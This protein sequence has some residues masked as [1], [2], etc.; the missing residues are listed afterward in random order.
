MEADDPVVDPDFLELLLSDDLP[1][2]EEP[3]FAFEVLD[4]E[5]ED[6][7]FVLLLFVD[8]EVEA[9]G[10][11][12]ELP[13]LDVPPIPLEEFPESEDDP[14]FPW[15]DELELLLE[16]ESDELPVF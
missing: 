10:V 4:F 9:T 2:V 3:D 15:F 13:M 16:D 11:E 7:A 1:S 12:L 8:D 14:E 6:E 5:P